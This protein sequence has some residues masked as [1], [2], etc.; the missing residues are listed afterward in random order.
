MP[1]YHSHGPT[2]GGA[3]LL[4]GALLLTALTISV[5]GCGQKGPLYL[6]QASASQPAQEAECPD[7]RCQT[8]A[9]VTAETPPEEAPAKVSDNP[10]N[11]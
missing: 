8:K 5:A 3:R 10:P 6:P 9:P 1:N 2:L 11:E 7:K 4:R